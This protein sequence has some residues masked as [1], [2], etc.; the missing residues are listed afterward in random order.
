INEHRVYRPLVVT[1]REEQYVDAIR[2]NRSGVKDV[3]VVAIRPLLAVDIRA[4]LDPTGRGPWADVL[5][6]MGAD[7]PLAEVLAN[8]LMLW[9]ARLVHDDMDPRDLTSYATRASLENHLLDQ[10]A[11]AVYE[12]ERSRPWLR[13][14]RCSGRQAERWLAAL[15]Y[16]PRIKRI[17]EPGRSA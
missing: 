10:F 6:R 16:D 1:S 2:Q 11:S 4:Y 9:L 12:G 8:P 5:A 15:A 3:L 7:G 13:G 14:F 17:A